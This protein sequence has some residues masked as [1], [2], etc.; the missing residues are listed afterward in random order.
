MN[1]SKEMLHPV[2][3][4]TVYIDWDVFTYS[5][6]LEI[7]MLK[8]ARESGKKSS[9]VCLHK[10]N[11]EN[12][13]NMII[14]LLENSRFEPHYHPNSK[15]ESYTVLKGTLYVNIYD[16]NGSVKEI[17]EL[18][19]DN[20][21]YMHRNGIRHEPYTKNELCIYQEVYHGNYNKNYDVRKFPVMG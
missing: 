9:R 15:A 18:S 17:L 2:E 8:L 3:G 5:K 6:D 12:T 13:Q 11:L 16:F 7:K 14:F 10:S 21:P 4:N 19:R 1:T 20:T